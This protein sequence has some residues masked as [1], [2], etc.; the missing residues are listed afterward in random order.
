MIFNGKFDRL[1][2]MGGDSMVSF[3]IPTYLA[4]YAQFSDVD[5]KIEVTEIKSKRSLQ[6]NK[7]LWV[8]I[9]KI[10]K[11]QQMDDLEIY[12]QLIEMSNIESVF[13]E[14]LAKTK[15]ILQEQFRVVKEVETRTSPKGIETVL[16]KC[17]FGTSHFSTE[18]MSTF[19]DRTLDYA[20]NCGID[21]TEYQD[22]L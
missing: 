2:N 3:I 13:F 12:T 19:I 21:V 10:A 16:F 17:Y 5:Y 22:Y 4:K 15:Q 7:Y 1:L 9:N 11:A 8:L 14:G 6:Q 20:V 18:E